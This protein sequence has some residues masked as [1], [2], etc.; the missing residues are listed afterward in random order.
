MQEN[1]SN[2]KRIAKNTLY[3]YIRMLITMVVGLYTSRVVLATLGASD[4]GLYNV[5]GGI[6]V[7]LASINGTLATGT[8]RFLSYAIGENNEEKLNTVFSTAVLIHLIFAIILFIIAETI[9]LWFLSC[10]MNIP[11]GRETAAF[12]VYQF[13]IITTVINIIQVPYM[14]AIIAHERMNVYAYMSIYD[15]AAKLLVVYLILVAQYDKLIFYAALI[16]VVSTTSA[17]LYN[18][19]CRSKFP[20]CK[21]HPK[22]DWAVF[23]EMAFFSGWNIFGCVAV[24]LQ[25]QGLNILLNIFFNTIVNAARG[26]AVQINNIIIQF[27]NNF[28]T[29]VNPQIVKLYAAGQ[30]EEMIH[31]VINNSKFAGFLYLIIAVPL[32]VEIEFVLDIWLVEYP[33][34]TIP[35][36]RIILIQSL[37]Q[38]LTRPVVMVVHAVGKMKGPNLTAGIALLLAVP[39]TYVLLKMGLDPVSVFAINLI[40]WLLETFFELYFENKYIDFP[41]W[42]FY[43]NVYLLVFPIALVIVA[44]PYL[45]HVVL[46]IEGWWRF[47]VVCSISVITSSVVIFYFGLS[48]HLREMVIAKGKTIISS[49]LHK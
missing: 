2:N 18:V 24:P 37:I 1:T 36:V 13:S 7:V 49:K 43:K 42:G 45:V 26:I 14:S 15:V 12:W 30:K 23:R 4:F 16:C 31:L 25:T 5:I 40:P 17:L 46:P 6:V 21:L 19:Y 27:V 28:Q 8:Q 39:M 34:Y 10:K 22:M 41:I 20:E 38:T 47:L 11:I 9:G 32:F 3:M 44:V 48:K 33:E 35:F 29:A